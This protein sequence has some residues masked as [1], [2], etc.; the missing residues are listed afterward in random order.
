MSTEPRDR[1]IDVPELH[2]GEVERP[3]RVA[4]E[5]DEPLEKVDC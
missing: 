1:T 5:G 2:C 4:V 3:I